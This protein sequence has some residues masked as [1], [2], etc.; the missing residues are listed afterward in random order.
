MIALETLEKAPVLP[1]PL[2]LTIG[3][4][5]GVHR[6]HQEILHRVRKLVGPMGTLGVLTFSNHPSDILPHRPLA[7]KIFSKSLKLKCLEKTQVTVVYNL[8]FTLELAGLPYDVFLKKVRDAY[9][10]DF[11]VLGEGATLG[12]KRE[13]TPE[14]IQELGR[15]IG[16]SVEYLPKLTLGREVV[17]SGKI[18]EY[19]EKGNLKKASQFL[20][21]PYILEGERKRDSI[22]VDPNLCLPPNGAYSVEIDEMKSIARMEGNNIFLETALPSTAEKISIVFQ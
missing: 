12:K 19:I 6:G 10:F 14:K 5:D 4:F 7:K 13:G 15:E 2:G 11:L 18:R 17:S 21:H 22:M 1:K 8:E 20:G 9:P 3:S 16:F